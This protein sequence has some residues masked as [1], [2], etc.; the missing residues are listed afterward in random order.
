MSY[1]ISVAKAN[2]YAVL[3]YSRTLA[4][5][6]ANAYVILGVTGT[7][8]ISKA[9]LYVILGLAGYLSINKANLY[10]ILGLPGSLNINKANVYGILGL[11][12][13]L[14]ISKANMYVILE[15]TYIT[16]PVPTFTIEGDFPFPGECIT[17]YE[18]NQIENE[19]SFRAGRYTMKRPAYIDPIYNIN[20][21]LTDL[22]SDDFEDIQDFYEEKQTSSYFYILVRGISYAVRFAS[23]KATR[24]DLMNRYSV[25]FSVTGKRL[26]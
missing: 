19:N 14:N 21:K 4:I 7:L 12:G 16:Y 10:S 22:N 24:S 17:S 13:S 15:R 3:K 1:K 26:S 2:V 11:P 23:Y 8:N 20:V 5:S 18:I 6:K 25:D 9:N